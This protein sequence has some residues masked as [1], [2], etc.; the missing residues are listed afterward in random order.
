MKT[1][2]GGGIVPCILDLGT[3]RR[4]VVS[5][6]PRLLYHQGKSPWYPLCRRLG[7]PQSFSGRGGEEKSSQ[8]LPGLDPR[9][10]QYTT[11]LSRVLMKSGTN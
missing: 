7:G 4:W 3:R 11:Q 2:E 8:P 10:I 1:N 6:T 5:F 9:I